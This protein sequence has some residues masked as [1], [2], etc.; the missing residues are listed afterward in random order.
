MHVWLNSFLSNRTQSVKIDQCIS[1]LIKILSGV[2]QGSV[3]GPTLFVLYINDI[4]DCFKDLAVSS[5]LFADDLK[6]YTSYALTD[7]SCDL[8][9]ALNRL[10]DWAKTWQ[11]TIN[12]TKCNVLRIVNA[13]CINKSNIV[14]DLNGSS[15][16]VQSTVKDLGVT[17]DTNLKFDHH[18]SLVVHKSLQRGNLILKCFQSQDRN[19][20]MRAFKVY[21]RPLLEYATP[22]WSPHLLHLILKI[23][24]VQRSF[25]KRLLGLENV[26]YIDRLKTL[27]V[28]SLERRRLLYDLCTCFKIVHRYSDISVD[29][30]KTECTG[31]QIH[32]RG[33]NYK[34][35]KDLCHN[36]IRRFF[37]CNRICDVWNSLPVDVVNAPS[38]VSFKNRVKKVDLDRFLTVK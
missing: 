31:S 30:N 26:S 4:V 28:D 22:V 11:L 14:Y 37:F 9:E 7:T 23:E 35:S 36:D 6:L 27:K 15:L 29:L 1:S 12:T 25:T 17:V 3:L 20:L 33:H 8:T 32:T 19:L 2:P 24:S 13:R 16:T 34:L 21:V 18:I 38:V 10:T 5:K